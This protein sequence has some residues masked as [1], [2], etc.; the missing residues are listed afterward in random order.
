MS[1][2]DI[3][4]IDAFINAEIEIIGKEPNK[5]E[6]V[7]LWRIFH[8]GVRAILIAQLQLPAKDDA[9]SSERVKRRI[10]A[11]KR[12]LEEYNGKSAGQGTEQQG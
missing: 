8:N 11:V 6:Q 4:E 9:T 5:E 10:N 12:Y 2:T 7:Q 1:K 3:K